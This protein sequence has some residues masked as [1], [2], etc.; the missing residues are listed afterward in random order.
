MRPPTR[1]ALRG[2]VRKGLGAA[3]DFGGRLPFDLPPN[4]GRDSAVASARFATDSISAESSQ[5]CFNCFGVIFM[6]AER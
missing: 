5:I 1:R 6:R 2:V 3:A 4:V